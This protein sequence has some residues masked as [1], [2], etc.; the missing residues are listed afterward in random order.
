MRTHGG[1]GL[2]PQG[3]D[4]AGLGGRFRQ[5]RGSGQWSH[6]RAALTAEARLMVAQG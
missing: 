6:R 3:H 2:L 5:R 1:S 4:G